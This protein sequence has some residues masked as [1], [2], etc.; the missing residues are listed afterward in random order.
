MAWDASTRNCD[1]PVFMFFFENVSIHVLYV[2]C[3][4]FTSKCALSGKTQVP[5]SIEIEAISCYLPITS[6][7]LHHPCLLPNKNHGGTTLCSYQT[8]ADIADDEFDQ[9]TG[10]ENFPVITKVII[11]IS[12]TAGILSDCA[13]CFYFCV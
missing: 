1:S 6:F 3:L 9:D 12:F 5:K 2:F 13:M 11:C 7:R 8:L 10:N 4:A